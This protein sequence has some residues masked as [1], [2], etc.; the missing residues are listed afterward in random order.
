MLHATEWLEFNKQAGIYRNMEGEMLKIMR[1]NA[2]LIHPGKP[3]QSVLS[4]PI[5]ISR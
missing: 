1:R 3:D 5:W 4:S 2:G